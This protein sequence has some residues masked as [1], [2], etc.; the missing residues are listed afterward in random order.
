MSKLK[1]IT[2]RKSLRYLSKDK[3]RY[4]FDFV[5]F[6]AGF[7]ISSALALGISIMVNKNLSKEELGLYNYNKSLLEFLAYCFTINLYRSYP[8][9]NIL[10]N[11][12]SV[13]N[14]VKVVNIIAFIILEL[15]A[16]YIT[17]SFLALLF[18]FFIFY[19]ERL[20][21]FRS[22]M[23]VKYV[24]IL[25]ITISLITLIGIL[26]LS[27]YDSVDS[28]SVLLV[29]GIGFAFAFFFYKKGIG[30][31]KNHEIITWKTLLLFTVPA[32]GAI[33]VKLSLDLSSQ[34]LIKS[35]FGFE[36]LS[37]YSSANRVLLSVK[38]FSSLLMM[39][40]PVVYYRE[41][42]KKNKKF[43]NTFRFLIFGVMFII[44]SL[45]IL[46]GD[47]IYW[48]M[49]ASKYVNDIRIYNILVVTELIFIL[50]SLWSIYLAFALKTHVSLVIYTLGAILNI[51]LLKVYL[52]IY[53]I[54]AAPWSILIS[55]VLISFLM[56]IMS[57]KKENVFLKKPKNL[58]Y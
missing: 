21:F 53:G 18:P 30:G 19:E 37:K 31:K 25:K 55:N 49:G 52:P 2:L 20:Y 1:R 24:N 33:I 44:A 32:L 7:A 46:F 34:Y 36:E 39:F 54:Y 56:I 4:F 22:I 11:N 9:W 3:V 57:Y 35:Q 51:F 50:G 41:I 6:S 45:A 28:N 47:K 38:L 29:F 42:T 10:G 23:K 16:Y 14:K 48:L 26:I 43:I 12:I 58:K 5:A 8:R 40:F 17:E 15:L 13:Y 27:F